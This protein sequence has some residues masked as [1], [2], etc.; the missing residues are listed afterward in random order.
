M[1]EAKSFNADQ[2]K[3]AAFQ[4]IDRG[5]RDVP[6]DQI[7]G[8]V[9]RYRDLDR[10][11]RLKAHVPSEKL[12]NVKKALRAGKNLPPVKLFQ[13]K[14]GY[15]ALDGNHRIAVAKEIGR[16]DIRAQVL[17]FL[18][19]K[20]TPENILYLER[21]D[22]YDQTGL[23]GDLKLTEFG[24]Y[25]YLLD[26]ISDHRA[27]LE[28]SQGEPVTIKK[29]AQD[30]YKT[31][32]Q[33]LCAII[34]KGRLL[35]FFPDRTLADLY[36]YIT[37][38]HWLENRPDQEH[39]YGIGLSRQVPTDME[40][41][42]KKMAN[43]DECK[44]PEMLREITA[45][46]LMNVSAKKEYKVVDK[47]F[48]LDE[49]REVHSVHGGYDIILK[50]VLRR[51]LVASDAETIGDFVHNQVRQVNG[52]KSTQTLIPGYSRAKE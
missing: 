26:Q 28:K 47:L 43:M 23:R 35:D 46:I 50:I 25:R 17:E 41:F 3:E 40:A 44:Y 7:V 36:T 48:A 31:I 4:K 1:D 49:V 18:P 9:G 27:Y 38:H 45:F 42:R 15:Y 33:P 14:D 34:D 20:D 51:D 16:E 8:S 37:L 30:W 2:Q 6:L 12:E 29:A 21:V 11:F 39:N 24:Q 22:F 19:S 5:I 32:Y 52:V 10:K 13:I